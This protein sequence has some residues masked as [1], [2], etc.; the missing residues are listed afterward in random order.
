MIDPTALATYDTAVP[1]LSGCFTF[2]TALALSTLAQKAA[3][4][5]TATKLVPSV[6]GIAT[7]CLASLASQQAAIFSH[8][9]IQNPSMDVFR[10]RKNAWAKS[11][12]RDCLE[13]G[14]YVKVPMHS[15]RV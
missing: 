12:Y 2:G 4:I 8:E 5:S 6:V 11:P 3:G 15:V 13:I 9:W 14:E 1:I 7:V 10:K